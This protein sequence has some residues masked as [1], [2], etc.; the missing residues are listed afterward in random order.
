[1][2]VVYK[3][4]DLR[5]HRFVALKFLST[6]I[7]SNPETL[8]RF[9]I[10]A[11]SISALNHSHIA[12][13]HAMEK[14]GW[15][16]FL[17]LE[18]LP[19]GT[20]RRR[21]KELRARHEPFPVHDAVSIAI[22]IAGGLNHA[23]R[24]GIVHRDVKPENV[25]FNAEGVVRITDFGLAK[26]AYSEELTKT[27]A[28]LGTAAYMAPEQ[29][30]ENQT[31][32][33]SDLFS[34]GIV[35]H[36]MIAGH[37]PF[38]GKTELATMHAVVHDPPPPLRTI[39]P[40]VAPQLERILLQLLDKDPARRYQTGASLIADLSNLDD[41]TQ[42][43]ELNYD[44][45]TKTILGL[46]G[47]RRRRN[48][49]PIAAAAAVILA[50]AG[51][52][53]WRGFHR[54]PAIPAT[55][56]LAVL[57]FTA[58]SGR[59]EDVAFGNGL[60]GILATRLGS[61]GSSLWIVPGNDLRR[62]RVIT[63]D[64]ARR[65]FGVGRVLTGTVDRE[66]AGGPRVEMRL[67][68][69]ASG[70]TLR[71]A[72]I[73]S[74]GA[75]SSL[76]EDVMKRA[77]EMLGVPLKTNEPG[78]TK[79]SNAYDYYVRA[80]GYLQRYDQAGNVGAAVQS[81]Q[82]AIRLDPGYAL[83]Y[84]GLSAAYWREYKLSSEAQ[85]LERARDAAMQALSRN[86]TLDTPHITLGVIAVSAG[87]VD[88]GIRQ[89]ILALDRDPVSADA[90]RELANAYV[91]AG[92]LS[93]AETTYRRAIQYRPD[94]WLG[95]FDL[96][97]FYNAQARYDEAER[98]LKK[99]STLTPDNYLIH[100]NL[101]GVQ[102]ARGEWTEAEHSFQ[103][104]LSLR[105]I[106]SVYSNLGTLYIFL[107]RYADAIPVLEQAIALSGDERYA[108]L[109]WGNLGDALKWTPARRGEAPRAYAKAVELATSQLEVNPN[110]AVLLSQIACYQAKAGEA[111]AAQA[112]MRDAL[113]IAPA[114]PAVLYRSAILLELAGKR[115]QSL[116]ALDSALTAGYSLSV[117]EREPE[118]ASLR[119]D[120]GYPGVAAHAKVR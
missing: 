30:S 73:G 9:E 46:P 116:A 95:Y 97:T 34:L 23:H 78:D 113:K 16:R 44:G 48:P 57:P 3:A 69:T 59:A 10:E 106:G 84:A 17:V 66:A 65:V 13:I 81:F 88:E 82:E 51:A 22:A 63:P 54:T 75:G 43:V 103:K 99:A 110:D 8:A 76:Q 19:G 114:D 105:P 115:K 74:P 117:I 109:I 6:E 90:Y 71:Q 61:A 49:V 29:A 40:E 64:D 93:D 101:G 37:R 42:T 45:V 72:T 20:L 83:A 11:R 27:G 38:T 112:N 96:A 21:I 28:A 108:Y 14:D 98:A 31:S 70:R 47:A 87:R 100:R 77:T 39:R 41:E 18:F 102:M 4:R 5:L 91:A 12:T 2:G 94:F 85:Y 118:F 68:D 7:A 1:M 92:K 120:P 53:A 26:S 89:L 104:A 24:A 35:L 107:G 52:A 80:S 15:R 62:N 119:T 60:S 58:K 86:D 32:P 50:A 25:M 33:L 111:A 56:Q 79:A 55:T 67:I 36:E